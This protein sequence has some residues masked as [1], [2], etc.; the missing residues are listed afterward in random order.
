[1]RPP[2]DG[3]GPLVDL[4]VAGGVWYVGVVGGRGGH[5]ILFGLGGGVNS[6]GVQSLLRCQFH[7]SSS[8]AILIHSLSFP[9]LLS[10]CFVVFLPVLVFVMVV[11]VISLSNRCGARLGGSKTLKK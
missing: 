5:L 7:S 8:C 6:P 2:F 9:S 10:V 1:M 3:S 11:S 4:V